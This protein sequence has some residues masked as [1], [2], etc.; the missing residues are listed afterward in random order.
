MIKVLKYPPQSKID[1]EMEDLHNFNGEMMSNHGLF[2]GTFIH[3]N[4]FDWQIWLN[5][6]CRLTVTVIF[7]FPWTTICMLGFENHIY[8]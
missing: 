2:L 5:F 7:K 8:G 3:K 6:L 1:L 4:G